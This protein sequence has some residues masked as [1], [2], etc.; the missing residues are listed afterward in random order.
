MPE[1]LLLGAKVV[2]VVVVRLDL[3]RYPLDDPQPVPGE[4][5]MRPQWKH[6]VGLLL[7]EL[8]KSPSTLRL[9]YVADIEDPE[10][11]DR[12]LAAVKKEIADAWEAL[13]CCY[14][15]TIEPEV[16]WRTGEPPPRS[17]V[18]ERAGR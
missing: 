8:K 16:F 7:G 14:Q 10:L 12:R 18:R 2:P 13:D 5:E 9:S 4:V 3:E 15:L 1:L 11:V 17:L 6:R